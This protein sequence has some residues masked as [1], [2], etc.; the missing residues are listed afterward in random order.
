MSTRRRVS[1]AD[2]AAA[3][4]RLKTA[5]V[6]ELTPQELTAQLERSKPNR[7]ADVDALVENVRRKVLDDFVRECP[8]DLQDLIAIELRRRGEQR[9]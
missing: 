5:V 9:A 2:L 4:A 3:D 8:P 1:E 7:Q 6:S